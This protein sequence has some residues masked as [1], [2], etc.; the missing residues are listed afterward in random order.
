LGVK[1]KN[2]SNPKF[3]IWSKIHLKKKKRKMEQIIDSYS[4]EKE[5]DF[6]KD[7]NS[8]SSNADNANY[9]KDYIGPTLPPNFTIS[10]DNSLILCYKDEKEW[11]NVSSIDNLSTNNKDCIDSIL[12]PN[13]TISSNE[14]VHSDDDNIYNGP[15]FNGI[16]TETN[17]I[18]NQVI[19]KKQK[20]YQE[21]N[22]LPE[23]L[24]SLSENK[25]VKEFTT[26]PLPYRKKPGRYISKK[27]REESLSSGNPV[28]IENIKKKI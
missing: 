27:E 19:S 10:S 18:D 14:E 20:V 3:F 9:S 22:S 12:P 16:S 11:N 6:I 23:D 8:I 26:I 24:L 5:E 1:K 15:L 2:E 13:Y 17:S 7:F 4:D 21:N 28:G 25:S